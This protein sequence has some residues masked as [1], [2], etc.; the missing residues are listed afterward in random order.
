M[1]F[2]CEGCLGYFGVREY[3]PESKCVKLQMWRDSNDIE[4]GLCPVCAIQTI[5]ALS[6]S[7]KLLPWYVNGRSK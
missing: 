6:E 2:Q 7:M 3:E 4:C 5:K 1:I